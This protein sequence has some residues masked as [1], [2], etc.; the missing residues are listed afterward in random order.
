MCV[1]EPK[2]LEP[3]YGDVGSH[4]SNVDS[5]EVNLD[6]DEVEQML[7]RARVPVRLSVR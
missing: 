2:L 1:S 6:T 5:V 7:V 4:T 3:T